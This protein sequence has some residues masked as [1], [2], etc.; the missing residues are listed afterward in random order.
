MGTSRTLDDNSKTF[1]I[2][3]NWEDAFRF[4]ITTGR[5]IDAT[6]S[7]IINGA[8]VSVLLLAFAM[9]G[10]WWYWRRRRR[11]MRSA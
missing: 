7:W 8:F 3:T 1:E 11:E 2:S 10:G 4:D 5:L 6:L 9:V